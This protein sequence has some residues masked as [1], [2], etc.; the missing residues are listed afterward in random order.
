MTFIIVSRSSD[1]LSAINNVNATKA[2]SDKRLPPSFLYSIL[3][4]SRN[5]KKRNAPI[6]LLPSMNE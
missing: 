4:S 3:F 6:L 2:L 5:H 1:L